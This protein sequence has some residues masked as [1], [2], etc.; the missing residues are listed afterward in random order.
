LAG[1]TLVSAGENGSVTWRGGSE[2]DWADA[3]INQPLRQGAQI[4]TSDQSSAEIQFDDGS[5]IGLMPG[6]IISRQTLFIDSKGEFTEIA[7]HNGKID[8]GK[9]DNDRRG[10]GRSVVAAPEVARP[11]ANPELPLL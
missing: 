6:T 9:T 11:R 8:S 2:G 3:A 5:R 10:S 4:S 7:L 1:F